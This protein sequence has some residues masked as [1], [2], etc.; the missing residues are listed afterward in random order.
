MDAFGAALSVISFVFVLPYFKDFIGLDLSVF[1][2]LAAVAGGFFA[3][4]LTTALRLPLEPKRFI[5]AIAFSNSIY[6]FLT[7][8]MVLYNWQEIKPLGILYF[9]LDILILT[10]L[11]KWELKTASK[12]FKKNQLPG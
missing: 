2:L 11:I 8:I 6:A 9:G 5:K 3:F 7:L 1:Y 10:A 4:S 12:I